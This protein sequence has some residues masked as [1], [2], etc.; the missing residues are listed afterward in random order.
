MDGW[1]VGFNINSIA[2]LFA[3]IAGLVSRSFRQELN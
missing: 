3:Y 1:A 2:G